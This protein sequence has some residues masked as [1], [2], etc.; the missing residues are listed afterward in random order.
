MLP[1]PSDPGDISKGRLPLDL[2]PLHYVLEITPD[3]YAENPPF[4]FSGS[5]SIRFEALATTSEIYLNAFG[6]VIPQ[7]NIQIQTAPDS[8]V[9][10]DDPIFVD[11]TEDEEMHFFIISVDEDG[12]Q[13]GAHYILNMTF[14]GIISLFG[15][16]RRGSYDYVNGTK[17]VN[18]S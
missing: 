1:A 12:I 7:V 13:E 5:V 4:T 18:M 3:I 2:S 15:G 8:P 16:L 17:Q 14:S 11:S 9:A 10:A 6:L